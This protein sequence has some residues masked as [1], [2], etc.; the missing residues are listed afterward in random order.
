MPAGLVNSTLNAD[1]AGLIYTWIRNL[2]PDTSP[3]IVTPMDSDVA[4][5]F[6]SEG[7][8][9]CHGNGE[10]SAGLDLEAADWKDQLV[11]VAAGSVSDGGVCTGS[12]RVTAADAATS[13]LYQKITRTH[14]CG[15]SMPF[16]ATL[17][18]TDAATI[19]NWINNL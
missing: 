15:D 1:G 5:I 12:V 18:A 3:E 13:L 7:C 8:Y 16:G 11:G 4:S 10:Q 2:A 9:L 17:R 14:T 19:A 6:A